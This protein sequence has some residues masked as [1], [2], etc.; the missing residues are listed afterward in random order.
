MNKDGELRVW[1]IPQMP[2]K[3]FYVD[4]LTIREAQLV[5]DTLGKYDAFQYENNIKPDYSNAG[6]V[7]VYVDGDWEEWY[8][9]ATG[10]S[11]DE[12]DENRRIFYGIK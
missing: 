10:A 9:E 3:A 2:M 1:W 7:E 5:L 12:L 4:V 11:I 6:G 8:D